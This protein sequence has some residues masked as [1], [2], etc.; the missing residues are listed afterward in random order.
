MFG[1]PK[2][3]VRSFTQAVHKEWTRKRREVSTRWEHGCETPAA[4][5]N[6]A[7]KYT[8]PVLQPADTAMFVDNYRDEMF[9]DIPKMTIILSKNIIQTSRFK[10]NDK[11]YITKIN[12]HNKYNYFRIFFN[13][14][15][16]K[17]LWVN[18]AK[19]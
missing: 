7:K 12:V 4:S 11:I 15:Q 8:A 5:W 14:Q 9:R 1:V 16:G 10:S 17:S 18:I 13:F 6:N 19:R 2:M 3:A